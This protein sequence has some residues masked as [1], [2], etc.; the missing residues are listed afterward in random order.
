MRRA[1]STGGYEAIRRPPVVSAVTDRGGQLPVSETEP[2][3]PLPPQWRSAIDPWY[4]AEYYWRIDAPSSRTTWKRP[5][6]SGWSDPVTGQPG[7]G[8]CSHGGVQAGIGPGIVTGSTAAASTASAC[9]PCP[10]SASLPRADVSRTPSQRRHWAGDSDT[11]G[12]IDARSSP[13]PGTLPRMETNPDDDVQPGAAEVS[14]ESDTSTTYKIERMFTGL[15]RHE[16]APGFVDIRFMRSRHRRLSRFTDAQI[17]H[18]AQTSYHRGGL[19]FATRTSDS[20]NLQIRLS[21]HMRHPRRP[22]R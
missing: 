21:D 14:S 20:G 18:A 16:H 6:T 7:E 19:C 8:D 17:A 4:G 15:L 3:Q 5:A 9:P 13:A 22:R 1:S 2:M 12:E 10:P 11:Q